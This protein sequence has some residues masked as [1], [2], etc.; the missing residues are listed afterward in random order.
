MQGPAFHKFLNV[1]RA[2]VTQ[3]GLQAALLC[4]LMFQPASKRIYHELQNVS[5]HVKERGEVQTEML[6]SESNRYCCSAIVFLKAR[7]VAA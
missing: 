4:T 6:F 1:P 2:D 3:T 5:S 7:Q